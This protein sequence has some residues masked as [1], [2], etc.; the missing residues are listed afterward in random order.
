[1][2]DVWIFGKWWCRGWLVAD[3]WISTASILNLCAISVDRYVAVTRPV[4]YRS[5]M[6]A[7]LAKSIVAGVWIVSFLICCPPLWPQWEPSSASF[8]QQQQQPIATRTHNYNQ[9]GIYLDSAGKSE[10]DYERLPIM[11]S[12]PA[13]S[14]KIT[15]K[16]REHVFSLE[17]N[18]SQMHV[19]VKNSPDKSMNKPDLISSDQNHFSNEQI[20]GAAGEFKS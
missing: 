9:D 20:E 10:I 18:T 13:S 3:V 8:Q 11:A 16:K 5:I 15:R 6:T 14:R 12:A 2:L 1:M 17:E 4:K 19:L 7:R